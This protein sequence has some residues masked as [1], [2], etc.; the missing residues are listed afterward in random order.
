MRHFHLEGYLGQ[1]HRGLMVSRILL[2]GLFQTETQEKGLR[3]RWG[4][5]TET[6]GEQ[7]LF[8]TLLIG[9]SQEIFWRPRRDS[10]PR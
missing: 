8:C 9:N 10:N 3:P 5:V 7:R 1:H 6:Q 4:I 2:V